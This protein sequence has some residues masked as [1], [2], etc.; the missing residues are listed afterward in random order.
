[1]TVSIWVKM[2]LKLVQVQ[3]HLMGPQLTKSHKMAFQETFRRK[4]CFQNSAKF[5]LKLKADLILL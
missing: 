4:K 3:T 5:Q 2:K 1:M